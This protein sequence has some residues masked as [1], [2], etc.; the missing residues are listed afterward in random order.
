VDLP[1]NQSPPA[2]KDAKTSPN[3]RSKGKDPLEE[4][5]VP[6]SDSTPA[7]DDDGWAPITADEVDFTKPNDVLPDR[8]TEEEISNDMHIKLQQWQR[9]MKR[10]N[11]PFERHFAG[12]FWE[13]F[14]DR[15]CRNPENDAASRCAGMGVSCVWG[16]PGPN[17]FEANRLQ[18]MKQ[19][20]DPWMGLQE[21]LAHDIESGRL[22]RRGGKWDGKLEYTDT[23][24]YDVPESPGFDDLDVGF[25][26]FTILAP[27]TEEETQQTRTEETSK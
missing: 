8:L 11:S 21:E 19:L 13:E 20:M 25:G 12:G 10:S 22:V 17:A 4:A 27:A 18:Y 14:Y 15:K 24:N 9:T 7:G 16:D 26:D 23:N 3:T 5:H 6:A 2:S 1:F